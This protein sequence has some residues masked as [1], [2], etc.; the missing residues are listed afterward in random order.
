MT[1]GADGYMYPPYFIIK[2]KSKKAPCVA[3]RKQINTL[4]YPEAR[5]FCTSE[6]WMTQDSFHDYVRWIYGQLI[7]RGVKMPV[8]LVR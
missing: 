6:G 3:S 4:Y 7:R 1:I 5:Y 2:S 8:V